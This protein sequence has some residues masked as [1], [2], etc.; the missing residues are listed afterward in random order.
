[1]NV[2]KIRRKYSRVTGVLLS[3]YI[4]DKKIKLKETILSMGILIFLTANIIW[5]FEFVSNGLTFLLP[6]FLYPAL[7]ILFRCP[8]IEKFFSRAIWGKLGEISYDVYIW[9]NPMFILIKQCQLEVNLG[10]RISMYLFCLLTWCVG[11]ISYKLIELP[12]KNFVKTKLEQ[13]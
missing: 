9:H 6:F 4:Y 12:L 10:T 5:N 1:M 2:T 7:I 13:G 3:T 11:A 8:I